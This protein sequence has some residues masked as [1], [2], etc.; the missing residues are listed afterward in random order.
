MGLNQPGGKTKVV[1]GLLD[2]IGD[3]SN[4][5]SKQ[6]WLGKGNPSIPAQTI[7]ENHLKSLSMHQWFFA[8]GITPKTPIQLK[9]DYV[10]LGNPSLQDYQDGPGRAWTPRTG[11]GRAKQIEKK[12]KTVRSIKKILFIR[13]GPG[14][15]AI[16]VLWTDISVLSDGLGIVSKPKRSFSKKKVPTIPTKPSQA[17]NELPGTCSPEGYFPMLVEF[18]PDGRKTSIWEYQRWRHL[19][20]DH[21]QEGSDTL[22]KYPH[23]HLPD[24]LCPWGL[25]RCTF[26]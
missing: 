24:C 6:F 20:I 16:S 1:H 4:K 9:P 19:P 15:T 21:H 22:L 10:L 14:R 3:N 13:T 11:F 2:K 18:S 12:V 25:E 23:H 26:H 8:K 17:F 7:W 5:K